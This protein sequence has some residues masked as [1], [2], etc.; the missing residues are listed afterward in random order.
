MRSG[1]CYFWRSFVVVIKSG[2]N[3]LPYEEVEEGG[4]RGGHEGLN[5]IAMDGAMDGSKAKILLYG[6]FVEWTCGMSY[7]RMMLRIRQVVAYQ[8]DNQTH[9]WC[10]LIN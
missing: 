5:W 8:T 3:P 1:I 9:L 4:G 2:L 6:P 10:S 7:D